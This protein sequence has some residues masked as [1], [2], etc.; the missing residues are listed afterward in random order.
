ME[1]MSTGKS[2]RSIGQW[3]VDAI[4][5]FF[6]LIC[7][8]II[9]TGGTIV[10]LYMH[11]RPIA[12]LD[13]TLV[14]AWG[15]IVLVLLM[16]RKWAWGTQSPWL[17]WFFGKINGLGQSSFIRSD[18]KIFSVFAIIAIGHSLKHLSIHTHAADMGYV[19]PALFYPFGG[20]TFSIARLLKSDLC[21]NG[22]YLGEHLSFAL[23]LL[24][25]LTV[26]VR[27]F[28]FHDFIIFW[29]Q[30]FLMG[31]AIAYFVRKG[32]TRNLAVGALVVTLIAISQRGLRAG[33]AFDFREDVLAFSAILLGIT[34]LHT[35]RFLA[36]TVFMAIAL[37]SKENV[38][39][40][41]PFVAVPIV[42]EKNLPL[43]KKER[44][45]T[46]TATLAISLFYVLIGFK[47]LIPF[48][49]GGLA[50]RQQIAVRL[51]ALGATPGL[52][53]WHCMRHPFD[54]LN[55][56]VGRTLNA[57][58][59]KY[60]VF[61][62]LPVMTLLGRSGWWLPALVG[63][64]MNEIGAETQIALQFHY[65]LILSAFLIVGVAYKINAISQQRTQ[66]LL[67][68][69]RIAC[70]LLLSLALSGRWPMRT[71][72]QEIPSMDN[73][74]DALFMQSLDRGPNVT[75]AA[76]NIAAQLTASTQLRALIFP[77][78]LP[79]QEGAWKEV[80]VLN[81]SDEA[82]RVPGRGFSELTRIVLDRTEAWQK[83]LAD[84][85]SSPWEILAESPSRRFVVI[86]KD[87][88]I[89]L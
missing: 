73:V 8:G 58:H 42:F 15:I 74:R 26:A 84:Q 70:A 82:S 86:V 52:I 40:V 2:K 30:A 7:I 56:F 46:A 49:A 64:L 61:V 59:L 13:L 31:G 65:E 69:P 89:A 19:H 37:L 83:S 75:G 36:Y 14:D 10:Q 71:L 80:A 54:T 18:L 32:P 77:A 87:T 33:A 85:A 45:W 20:E 55:F 39:L 57:P 21:L 47:F 35:R 17:D 51:Q 11:G 29:S 12:K 41:L 76:W 48:F 22:T 44:I 63:L 60:A 6:G 53:L 68:S 24:S 79:P 50:G 3:I 72:V 1:H 67:D 5:G 78:S 88:K 28:V 81:Q 4:T 16:Y 43:T 23:L 34:F 9:L 27:N 62:F 38:G 66:P 25:P